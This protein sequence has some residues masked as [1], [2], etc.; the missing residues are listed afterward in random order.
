MLARRSLLLLTLASACGTPA[1]PEGPTRAAEP[2]RHEHASRED[3]PEPV[4]PA[5][6]EPPPPGPPEVAAPHAYGEIA[7]ADPEAML[8][9][10][11]DDLVCF[12]GKKPAKRDDVRKARV[13][14]ERGARFEAPPKLRVLAPDMVLL[15]TTVVDVDG[16]NAPHVGQRA[17]LMHRRDIGWAITGDT[18]LASAACLDV[19]LGELGA[20]DPAVAACEKKARACVKKC[21]CTRPS[22]ACE[23]CK[24]ECT[25]LAVACIGIPDEP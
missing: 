12:D 13:E 17:V 9:G 1:K 20:A 8:A 4:K 3:P 16:D 19:D 14:T 21:A 6:P 23:S 15:A 11:A 2:A 18:E 5:E 10:Y 22:N 24:D 7:K 25:G